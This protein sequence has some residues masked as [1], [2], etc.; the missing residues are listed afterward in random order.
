MSTRPTPC[1][2]PIAFSVSIRRDRARASSRSR[3]PGR[4]ASNEIVIRSGASGAFSGSTVSLNIEGSGSKPGSSSGPPSCE[5]CQRLRSRE[6]GSFFVT[7]DRNPARR[8]VVDR[9]LARA[10]VPLAPGRDDRELRRERLYA[11]SKRTWSLPF[12]VQPWESAS[13]PV[14]ERDLDL[15]AGDERP[16]GRRA[17]EVVVLVDGAGLEDREDVVL[18]ELVLARRR[19]GTPTRRSSS[20][21]PRGRT[22][23]RP[24]RRRRRPRR[25]RSRSSP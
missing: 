16:C 25:P 24:G 19:G 17:E 7:G 18:R 2:P 14:F 1:R 6:Y 9:V 10:D 8:G 20:P 5:R 23:P 12:P 21:S 11:S 15:L 22:S 13:Q 3:R 4:P